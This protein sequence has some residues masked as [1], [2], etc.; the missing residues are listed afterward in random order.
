M[1]TLIEDQPERKRM[2]WTSDRG[3]RPLK[4][5]HC[6]L[7]A[8]GAYVIAYLLVPG[9]IAPV[10]WSLDDLMGLRAALT[11]VLAGAGVLLWRWV[12]P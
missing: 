11:G 6:G 2:A 1:L 3:P 7:L 5:R 12:R 4:S 9:V 10:G 8:V